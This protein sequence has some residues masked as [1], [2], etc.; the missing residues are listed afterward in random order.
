MKTKVKDGSSKNGSIL[1][2]FAAQTNKQKREVSCPVCGIG[3]IYNQINKHLDEECEGKID[4]DEVQI[5]ET[6]PN[7]TTTNTTTTTSK[8]GELPT[9]IIKDPDKVCEKAQE[10]KKNGHTPSKKRNLESG[11]DQNN[12]K[13]KLDT[14]DFSD[15]DDDFLSAFNAGEN[16]QISSQDSESKSDE[17]GSTSSQKENHSPNQSKPESNS[18]GILQSSSQLR[19][20]HLTI[21]SSSQSSSQEL[22]SS[23]ERILLSASL[24]YNPAKYGGIQSFSPKG[25]E[26]VRSQ[27]KTAADKYS[28]RKRGSA[29]NSAEKSAA[30][31]ETS[32]TATTK[33]A[34]FTE[35]GV[36]PE[37]PVHDPYTPS[38]RM[39]PG[40]VPYYVTNFEYIIQCVID[41]TDDRD[42]FEAEELRMIESYRSLPLSAR[43]LYVRLY[44]RKFAWIPETSI[45]YSECPDVPQTASI[46]VDAALLQ[47]KSQLEELTEMLNILVAPDIKLI[48]KEFNV[49]SSMSTKSEIVE[50]LKRMCSKKTFF[51]SSSTLL[52][53][54]MRRARGLVGPCYRLNSQARSVI[55]RVLCMWGAGA[56][57]GEREDDRPPSSLTTLL[58]TNQG[59]VSYPLYPILRTRKV[60]NVRADVLRFEAAVRLEEKLEAA[61]LAK[62]WEAGYLVYIQIK[63]EFES[64]LFDPD[65]MKSVYE[66][67]VFLRKLTAPAVLV[68]GLSRSV[69]LLEKMKKYGEAVQLLENLLE[70]DFL[71]KYRGAWYERLSLDLENHLKKPK[72]ALDKID[73]ALQ[74]AKVRGGRRLSL[75][76]RILKICRAKR[77]QALE[78]ELDRFQAR[79]D[80][81]DPGS[82]DLPTVVIAGKMVSKDGASTTKSVFILSNPEGGITYCNV[83]ELVREHYKGEGLYEGSHAEGAVLNSILGLLF[84]D[85]IYLAEV[86]DAFRDPAQAVPLDWDTDDFYTNRKEAIDDRLEEIAG[87]TKEELDAELNR[88]YADNLNVCSIVSWDRFRGPQHLAGLVSCMPPSK[89]ALML[90]RMIKDHRT[91]RSGL[92]DLTLWNPESG[93]MKFVEV[94]GPGD[95][96]S[97]KQI[98]WIRF[99]L[100]IGVPTEVCHVDPTGSLDSRG[101]K[102]KSP[103]K[104]RATKSPREKGGDVQSPAKKTAVKSK[105]NPAAATDQTVVKSKKKTAEANDDFAFSQEVLI[106]E[107][108]KTGAAKTRAKKTLNRENSEN[109]VTKTKATNKRGKRKVDYIDSEDEIVEVKF[110]RKKQKY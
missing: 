58:L 108:K 47:D 107:T 11:P 97:Y 96:L 61:M 18:N 90:G 94:K 80:W 14:D 53:K 55:N 76:H 91:F 9:D 71:H 52:N 40:Y 82:E 29:P 16:V 45:K 85:I 51:Q 109:K 32:V 22:T 13:T 2:M 24:S 57:W 3:V 34:L 89:V 86:P 100:K 92:P 75:H 8:L 26:I 105:R 10:A 31:S 38:K 39:D 42:L 93:E 41:C 88:A 87:W 77:N 84:W 25:A 63:A 56:W 74:D 36:L 68:Y 7:T 65:L 99:F 64:L 101:F 4:P 106:K 35:K 19:T 102:I 48:A 62:D 110:K 30:G 33:R 1:N 20:T 27:G 17:S 54:V 59:R 23:Q 21:H 6:E 15:E 49:K 98:L 50:E 28:P 46:L 81:E 69:E 83:E 44:N 79:P 43:K 37:M 103:K 67:P 72:L 70:T 60:F 66:L 78:A 73:L 12:K 5:I 104:Q 95:K